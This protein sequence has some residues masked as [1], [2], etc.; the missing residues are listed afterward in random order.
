[1][2]Y[3]HVQYFRVCCF[4]LALRIIAV[5]GI[6]LQIIALQIIALRTVAG[7][8]LPQTSRVLQASVAVTI[9]LIDTISLAKCGVYS[10]LPQLT[11]L[12]LQAYGLVYVVV[13]V[14]PSLKGLGCLRFW[15]QGLPSTR[16]MALKSLPCR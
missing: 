3:V 4:A 13:R 15:V 1:M 12:L 6:A 8:A 14:N 10:Q 9:L 11:N 5:Q 16:L 2:V 7:H